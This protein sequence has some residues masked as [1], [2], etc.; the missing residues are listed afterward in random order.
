MKNTKIKKFLA[1]ALIVLMVMQLTPMS[2]FA[3]SA[4]N[5]RPASIDLKKDAPLVDI[6]SE[7][8]EKRTEFSKT[9]LLEDGSYC[10]ISTYA[11]VH[12]KVNGVWENIDSSL[13]KSV[14]HIDDAKNLLQLCKMKRE[15]R[16][17]QKLVW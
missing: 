7:V 1:T 2:V 12:N 14:K 13:N 11:P 10:N 3:E 5:R 17:F 4:K 8:K 6:A 16:E 15:Y 9:Y